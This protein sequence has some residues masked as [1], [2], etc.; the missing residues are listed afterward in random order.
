[1]SK[2]WKIALALV[3]A[4][5]VASA[6]HAQ[7]PVVVLDGNV[8]DTAGQPAQNTL[9]V[10]FLNSHEIGRGETQCDSGACRFEIAIPDD[11]GIG[12][13]EPDGISRIQVGTIKVKTPQIVATPSSAGQRHAVYA[14]LALSEAASDMPPEMKEGQLGLMPDGGVTVINATRPPDT[15]LPTTAPAFS[16]SNSLAAL[17]ALVV[18]AAVCFTSLVI[19]ALAVGWLVYRWRRSAP[20]P[21]DISPR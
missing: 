14:V 20:S 12:S 5:G 19:A 7:A 6:A 3:F 17:A 4:I 13:A 11:S 1:M 21:T 16:I 15:P 9:V 18:M 10:V 8:V 2:L